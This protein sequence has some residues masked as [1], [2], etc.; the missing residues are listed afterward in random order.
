M[1]RQSQW[2]FEA[3]LLSTPNYST[4]LYANPEYL[5]LEWETSR[6]PQN[7]PAVHLPVPKGTIIRRDR[8]GGRAYPLNEPNQPTRDGSTPTQKRTQL[9]QII[10]W[11]KVDVSQRYTRGSGKTFC[12]I[13]A[14]D[15]CYLAR[16]YLPRV[17]WTRPALKKLSSGETVAVKYG[18]TVG[19]LNANSLHNWF[20]AFGAQFGWTQTS[21]SSILQNAANEGRVCIITGRRKDLS[22]SGHICA[23]V[24]ETPSHRAQRRGSEV[25]IPLQS[26]AGS[27]NFRY[28]GKK[29]WIDS[30]FSK[31]GFW[32]HS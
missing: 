26:Q 2:L 15:Y 25:L 5:T 9:A 17:W 31:F 13:Y 7:I 16:A 11:L 23:V 22:R 12:N 18:S 21:D 24:P 32:I 6:A 20:E 19:E 4:N 27:R 28:G 29:W 1:N 30:N 8:A 3:P 10:D 14:Y